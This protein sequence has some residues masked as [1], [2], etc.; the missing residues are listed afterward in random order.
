V[1]AFPDM[2]KYCNQS[3]AL[4]IKYWACCETGGAIYNVAARLAALHKTAL[5]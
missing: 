1:E 4:S 5:R 2:A 3:K